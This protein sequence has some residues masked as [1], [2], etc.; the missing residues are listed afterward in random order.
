MSL[1]LQ[2]LRLCLPV[3]GMWVGSV[4][5]EPRAHVPHGQKNQNIKAEAKCGDSLMVALAVKKRLSVQE[6]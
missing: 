4:V 2:W 6:T 3:Q 5:W 1:E